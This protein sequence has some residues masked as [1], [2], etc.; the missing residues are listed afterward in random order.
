MPMTGPVTYDME[1]LGTI[2]SDIRRYLRD[3]DDLGIREAGDLHD[4]RNF[5][6]VSMILFSLLNRIIDLGSEMTIAHDLG[7]PST[8]REIFTLLRK[9]GY[10]DEDLSGELRR[11]VTYRNLLSH[12]YQGI[13]GEQVFELT[14]KVDVIKKFAK[15]MQEKIKEQK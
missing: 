4:K 12:E 8:Y 3:L 2:C 1:R 5:Y 15:I 13:S 6:A 10:I 7:V 14:K 9:N 11:L